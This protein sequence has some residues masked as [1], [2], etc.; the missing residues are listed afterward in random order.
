MDL[1][2]CTYRTYEGPREGKSNLC[3]ITRKRDLAQK[4]LRETVEIYIA[5]RCESCDSTNGTLVFRVDNFSDILRDVG[6][7]KRRIIQ[8]LHEI[9]DK[10]YVPLSALTGSLNAEKLQIVEQY[11]SSKQESK[12]KGP[13]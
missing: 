2:S 11:V 1:E 5:G 10:G 9:A 3:A 7:P 4:N 6:I 8:G 12:Q 13:K